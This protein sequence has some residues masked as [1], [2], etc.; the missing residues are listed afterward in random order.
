MQV[1]FTPSGAPTLGVE[2]EYGIVS[3]QTGDLVEVADEI[4]GIVGATAS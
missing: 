4:L 1:E 3:Q 2:V